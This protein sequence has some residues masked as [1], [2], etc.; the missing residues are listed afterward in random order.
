MTIHDELIL[1]LIKYKLEELVYW[2]GH[3]QQVM[4]TYEKMTPD[5]LVTISEAERRHQVYNTPD[6]GLV[7]ADTQKQIAIELETDINWDFGESLR[8]VKKYRK[9][10]KTLVIIPK[11]YERFAPLYINEGF[12]VYLWKATRKWQCMRCGKT[13]YTKRTL[14][15]QCNQTLY[16]KV[17]TKAKRQKITC[18]SK[19]QR[20]IGIKNATFELVTS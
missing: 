17:K 15:P 12:R 18:N 14:K 9:K 20:L 3:E 5:V 8:Q 1:A 4:G 10:F 6:G 11:A 7:V 2:R 16:V 19:E 13:T